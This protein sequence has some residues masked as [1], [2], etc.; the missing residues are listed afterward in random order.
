VCHYIKSLER[1]YDKKDHLA[2]LFAIRGAAQPQAFRMRCNDTSES[3]SILHSVLV[4]IRCGISEECGEC[5]EDI[6][7]ICK[8][9]GNN[10]DRELNTTDTQIPNHVARLT[11]S[12][13]DGPNASSSSA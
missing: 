5:I 10:D 2:A 8:D 6:T 1:T 7:D 4:R 12:K 13:T 9:F 11:N 3:G